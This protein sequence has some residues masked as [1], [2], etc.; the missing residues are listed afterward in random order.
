M[1][2]GK[3]H[4]VVGAT[5]GAG[6][7]LWAARNQP[8]TATAIEAVGGA[9]GGYVGGKLPDIFDPPLHPRHRSVA[10]AVIPLIV[11]TRYCANNLG[12]WQDIFRK[13]AERE[14]QLRV[15]ARNTTDEVT[16]GLLETGYRLI[17]GMIAGLMAGYAS[18]IALDAVTPS[19]LPLMY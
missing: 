1:A 8:A 15:Q 17:A 3:T 10:H 12:T 18:H 16:H 9:L 5:T 19:S 14:A 6:F 2:N 13:L 7:A 11:A 4:E